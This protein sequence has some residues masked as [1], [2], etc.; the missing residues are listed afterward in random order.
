MVDK[1]FPADYNELAALVAGIK[2]PVVD[3]S[4]ALPE[5]Q[6]KWSYLS[7]L[8]NG[9]WIEVA[10]TWTYASATTI[11][12]PSNG[13]LKYQ[14]GMK[15][16]FKQ[17]GSYK[18]LPVSAVAATLLTT[19]ANNEF[20][21][22]N[23]TITNKAYSFI[24]LPYG[25][26]E[27][28]TWTPTHSRTGTNYTNFPTTNVAQFNLRGRGLRIFEKHTQNATPGG[29]GNQQFTLPIAPAIDS[30]PIDGWNAYDGNLMS[31]FVLVSGALCR[32]FKFD[33][34]TD[35]QGSRIYIA[36][37]VYEF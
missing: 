24:E 14:K 31:T 6:L 16:R 17:G 10:D 28:F 12:I 20:S 15:I 25:W 27:Y 13:T 11:T 26:P 35:V 23:A 5:D 2:L 21:V 8:L 9:G 22:A 33:A 3:E 4:E 18:Y 36:S 29:T 30:Q 19:I 37:G 32:M 7:T 34:T 1:L